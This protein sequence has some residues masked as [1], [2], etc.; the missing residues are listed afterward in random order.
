MVGR[1]ELMEELGWGGMA[2]VHVARQ[3]DL[4]SKVAL[5][6][7]SKLHEWESEFIARFVRE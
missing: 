4:G 3:T 2:V 7:L 6:E 5:K 1:Y